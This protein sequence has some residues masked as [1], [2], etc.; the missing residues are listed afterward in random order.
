MASAVGNHVC[1]TEADRQCLSQKTPSSLKA[2]VSAPET[3]G[4]YN[5]Q[6]FNPI[7][8]LHLQVRSILNLAGIQHILTDCSVCAFK[9]PPTVKLTINRCASDADD[10]VAHSLNIFHVVS[11][12]VRTIIY[13]E[14]FTQHLS[15]IT[16]F[17][18]T[19]SA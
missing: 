17:C 6:L 9:P 19:M 1:C 10:A 2:S 15:C 14:E 13:L 11:L 7:T 3:P 4:S 12:K 16:S 5:K 18:Q 8:H